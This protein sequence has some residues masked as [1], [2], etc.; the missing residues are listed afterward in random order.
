MI[1]GQPLAPGMLASH[2]APRTKV[3]LGAMQI[4]AAFREATSDP[5]PASYTERVRKIGVVNSKNKVIADVIAKLL[6][7][8][9]Q[10]AAIV[11]R[12]MLLR[13]ARGTGIEILIVVVRAGLRPT[14]V[15]DLD[16]AST[17]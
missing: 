5:F 6:D 4:S 14:V 2:Y 13:D 9:T 1:S 7:G 15:F 11:E 3:R 10:L 8:H 12:A 16:R 17:D